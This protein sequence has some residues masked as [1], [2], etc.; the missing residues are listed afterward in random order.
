MRPLELGLTAYPPGGSDEGSGRTSDRALRLGLQS[1]GLQPGTAAGLQ[2]GAPAAAR[3][4]GSGRGLR[5]GGDPGLGAGD[6]RELGAG[7]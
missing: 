6:G 2:S 7:G 3:I 5:C 4:G 1:G